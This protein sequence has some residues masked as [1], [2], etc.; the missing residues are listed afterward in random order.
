VRTRG[1]KLDVEY[2]KT[3]A[4]TL[5]VADLLLKALG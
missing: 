3:A 2:L 1:E 4:E 5:S